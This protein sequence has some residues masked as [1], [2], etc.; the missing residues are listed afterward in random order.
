MDFRVGCTYVMMLPT[1]SDLVS[2]FSELMQ[3]GKLRDPAFD[4]LPRS[5]VLHASMYIVYGE[6]P[7]QEAESTPTSDCP[8]S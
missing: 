6:R 4:R 3:I 5:E 8:L 2:S 7:A 1:S